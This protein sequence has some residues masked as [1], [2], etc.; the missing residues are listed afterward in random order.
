MND[1]YI[2]KKTVDDYLNEIDFL[3][4]NSSGG[5]I[6]KEFSLKFMNFI[7]LVNGT[8]G[9]ENKTPVMH[10]CMLDK[11]TGKDQKIANLCARGTAKTTLF[12]EYLVLYL[13]IFGEIDDFGKV[14]GMLYISD[15]MDNGVKS[16]RNSV[17]FRYNNSEFM[18]YWVPYA[19]FT[20]NYLEFKNKG[21]VRF[22]VKMFGAKSGIRG[23][24]IFNK[25]PVLAVMDDL[26]SDA[27]S[28]SNIAMQSIKDT[29]YSGV[30][31]ALHPTR[32]KMILNGTPFN[33]GDIV[34]EA[35]ES[36]AWK[37]NV[38]PICEKFPCTK[39]E[40][41]G[42]W[43][44]RFTYEYVNEQYQSALKGNNLKSFRQELMLRISSDESKLI[45]DSEI[46]YIPRAKILANK[47]KYNFYITTDF[48]TSS[49]QTADFAVISVW[50]YDNNRN[51]IWVDGICKRQTMNHTINQLFKYIQEY[52]PQSVGIEIS[53]QQGAF[54]NWLQNEM[55]TRNIYFN[56]T[57]QDG[58]L[59]IR[60]VTDKLSRFNLVV[61]LFKAGKVQ[62]ALE[63]KDSQ[64]LGTM[65]EQIAL[66]TEDG[67]KGKDDC[68]DTISMLQYMN[69]WTTGEPIPDDI[70]DKS[71]P[72]TNIWNRANLT[73]ERTTNTTNYE[74]YLV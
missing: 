34:Y 41:K 61:P 38:W 30:E 63:M 72:S 67:I 23:T 71:L 3:M 43:E 74:S 5:Y 47:N 56:L 4:L 27:D 32:R 6:P 49:K 17:E 33:K 40:F 51:W 70:P 15:S 28:K 39:K 66:V 54:I 68:I 48:A 8:Q 55:V 10:L 59:G 29:V 50:A 9:E 60:P 18:Q 2:K 14:E 69:P 26:V 13:S 58:H 24:K 73:N 35:I 1:I 46:I 64:V 11:I 42:A 12:M 21:G 45:Q 22:G 53:G 65:V 44:D 52:E 16:A 20:E 19:K 57:R 25:R 36:G 7:K 37:V 31:Y 62:F